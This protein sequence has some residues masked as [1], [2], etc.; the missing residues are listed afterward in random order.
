MAI[1][2]GLTVAL[3]AVALQLWP[4]V[5][6]APETT[7]NVTAF[8]G[9]VESDWTAVYYSEDN[10]LLVANDGGA[11]NGGLHV[12]SFDVESPL[13]EVQSLP[14]GR[15][16][17]VTVAHDVGGVDLAITIAAPDSIIR[18]YEL[19]AFDKLDVEFKLL[20]DWSAMCSW[21]S[22][23]RNQYF[24]IFG[25]GKAVQFLIRPKGEDFEIV[26]VR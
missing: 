17:T 11:E 25:K 14:V 19:P 9:T 18:V 13:P 3:A 10:P 16:K 24:Y 26:E 6:A 12:Y 1:M 22:K 21:K 7:L 23:S 2:T 15:T 5:H 20:G 8:T 4:V